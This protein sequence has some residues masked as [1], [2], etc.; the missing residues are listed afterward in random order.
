MRPP[1]AA[2]TVLMRLL[3]FAVFALVLAVLWFGLPRLDLARAVRAAPVVPG[4]RRA[5]RTAPRVRRRATRPG[6]ER[7]DLRVAP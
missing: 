3:V 5:G 7:D 1:D 2:A 4:R 6:E